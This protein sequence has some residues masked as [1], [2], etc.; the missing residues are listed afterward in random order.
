MSAPSQRVSRTHCMS[1]LVLDSCTSA[2]QTR[3]IF[4]E[5]FFSGVRVH[6]FLTHRE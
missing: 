5:T 1:A 3:G 4:P 2:P 6:V